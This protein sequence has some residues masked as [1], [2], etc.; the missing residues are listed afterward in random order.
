MPLRVSRFRIALGMLLLLGFS[1]HPQAHDAGSYG[2]VFRSRDFGATWLNADVGLF[3]NAPLAIAIDPQAPFHLLMGTDIGLLSS[4][5]GGRSWTVEARDLIVGPVFAV[6]FLPGGR[7]ALCATQNGVFR[8][9]A[10]GWTPVRVPA[11]AL[12]A[13]SF[14]SGGGNRLYLL[15]ADQLLGSDDGGQSFATLRQTA[16][17]I[18][19][20]VVIGANRE[21]M[22]AVIEGTVMAS[23]DG[24]RA[25]R[26]TDFGSRNEPVDVITLDAKLP[27]RVWGAHADRIY[28]SDDRGAT[29]VPVGRPLPE[30]GTKVRGIAADETATTLV[31]TTHRGTYRSSDAGGT[32][33]LQEGSLPGHLEAGPLAR[34]PSDPSVIYISYSLVPYMQIW[35]A[36]REGSPVVTRLDPVDLAGVAA[37]ALLLLLGGGL[38]TRGLMRLRN[39]ASASGGQFR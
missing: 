16:G 1:N 6:A 15:G 34:D 36:A 30:L 19:V 26:P 12:P 23:D 5:N 32:W 33:V 10:E 38:A 9:E 7:Q 28:R 25:W 39:A 3:L 2:G 22:L 21:T 24:G 17:E 14:A 18:T 35:R 8:L 20:L 11:S 13:R 27:E 31:L 4:H 29:W 37:F